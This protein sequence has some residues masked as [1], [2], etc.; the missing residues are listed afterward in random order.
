MFSFFDSWSTV[1]LWT[2]STKPVWCIVFVL[3]MFWYAHRP[4]NTKTIGACAIRG[5]IT[6]KESVCV[7]DGWLRRPLDTDLHWGLSLFSWVGVVPNFPLWD[8]QHGYHHAW[9]MD[10]FCLQRG[11]LGFASGDTNPT[12]FLAPLKP[13]Q[14][15]SLGMYSITKSCVCRGKMKARSAQLSDLMYV[16]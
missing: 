10:D 6:H 11:G 12:L 8:D 7:R 16:S 13:V 15:E 14:F 3:S 1:I 4:H 5:T 2:R 9:S